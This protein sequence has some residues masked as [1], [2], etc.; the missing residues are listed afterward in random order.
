M[1]VVE[2]HQCKGYQCD[3]SHASSHVVMQRSQAQGT[4]APLILPQCYIVTMLHCYNVTLDV[5]TT[6]S[7]TYT[8]GRHRWVAHFGGLGR[9]VRTVAQAKKH[10]WHW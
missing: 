10:T 4:G 1:F 6:G 8:G 9:R 2:L 7:N 5:Q 3:L